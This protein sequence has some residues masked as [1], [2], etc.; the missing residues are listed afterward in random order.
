MAKNF[1]QLFDKM[2]PETQARS[3]AKTKQ[4]LAELPLQ[5]L[6]HAL[7]LTQQQLADQLDMNQASLSKM[8]QRTDMLLSTLRRYLNAMGADLEL[9]AKF[10]NGEEVIITQF[11]G[12]QKTGGTR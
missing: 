5:E 8:E 3:K 4:L 10:S 7:D 11:E 2:S 1:K 9:K 6:R 12:L